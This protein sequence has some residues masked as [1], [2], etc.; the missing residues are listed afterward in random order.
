[1]TFSTI[2]T[3]PE[4][5]LAQAKWSFVTRRVPRG[6][7]RALCADVAAARPGDL[8]LARVTEIGQ[9]GGVQRTSGRRSA[10]FPGDLVVMAV[11]ARYASDQFEGVGEI[12][13]RGAELLAAGGSIGRVRRRHARMKPATRLMPLG[14][15]MTAEGRPVRLAD[16]A[17]PAG[18]WPPGLPVIGVLG[19]AMNSGKTLATAQLGLGLRRAGRRV[20][21]VKLTGTGAFGDYNEYDDTG[22]S[23]VAD[24][25]DAGL[26]STYLEPV[27]RIRAAAASLLA[28]AEAQGCDIA[29]V[30][31]ADG[32]FQRET[33]ALLADRAF[34]GGISGTLFACG[35][36]LAAAGGVAALAGHGHA[37][38]AVTGLVSCSPMAS[39]EAEAATGRRVVTKE[40]LADPAEAMRIAREAQAQRAREVA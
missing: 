33:A 31:I 2:A 19:T 1:M 4:T 8:V 5:L 10:L 18:D 27:A 3:P 26:A 22:A 28:A 35:D 36:P 30:E 21:L 23:F 7:A 16:H 40:A 20:A 6:H 9:H 39:E 24:F 32:L 11:A 34:M 37:P 25:T 15:L 29:V 17:L 14:R 12:D 13:P 38:L